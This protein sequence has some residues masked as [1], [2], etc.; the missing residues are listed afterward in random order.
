MSSVLTPFFKAKIQDIYVNRGSTFQELITFNMDDELLDLSECEF[1]G[2]ISEYHNVKPKLDMYI[3]SPDEGQILIDLSDGETSVLVK[4]R[5]VY[6]I[7][8]II[9]DYKI[10]LISGQV[11]VL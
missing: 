8:A 11:L 2:Y 10:K 9:G 5:Y 6:S 4:P 1:V 7:F 3:T